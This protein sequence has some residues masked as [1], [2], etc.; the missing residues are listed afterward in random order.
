MITDNT[1]EVLEDADLLDSVRRLR[2]YMATLDNVHHVLTQVQLMDDP[3][4]QS[5]ATQLLNDTPDVNMR[6][7]QLLRSIE[8]SKQYRNMVKKYNIN[9][10]EEDNG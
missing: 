1:P 4:V 3:T 6:V 5:Q 8:N 10:D 2:S 7:S 9:L